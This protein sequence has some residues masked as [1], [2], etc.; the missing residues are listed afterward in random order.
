MCFVLHWFWSYPS[1]GG[2]ERSRGGALLVSPSVIANIFCMG[3][4]IKNFEKGIRS[5]IWWFCMGRPV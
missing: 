4:G 2:V 3:T 5:G 1:R